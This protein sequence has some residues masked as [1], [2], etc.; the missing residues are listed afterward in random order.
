MERQIANGRFGSMSEAVRAGLELLEEKELKM[1]NLRRALR[2]GE[3]SGEP[4]VFDM[5]GYLTEKRRAAR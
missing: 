5:D 4:A 1:E 3:A 2:D